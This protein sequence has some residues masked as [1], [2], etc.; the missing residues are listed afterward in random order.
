[1]A[2]SPE[3]TAA[4]ERLL[5]ESLGETAR[6]DWEES[7]IGY[8]RINR[9]SAQTFSQSVPLRIILKFPQKPERWPR[10]CNDWAGSR[11]LQSVPGTDLIGPRCFGGDSNLHF[12]LSQEVKGITFTDMLA[13]SVEGGDDE[14]SGTAW[15]G[16]VEFGRTLGRLHASTYGFQSDYERIRKATGPVEEH[17]NFEL[18]GRLRAT[19]GAIMALCRDWEVD[20]D[21]R[22]VD[23]INVV[24]QAIEDARFYLTYTHIDLNP[25]NL[26]RAPQGNVR[27]I[28]FDSGAYRH[29]LL[30]GVW[31]RLCF[32]GHW[33]AC[34]LPDELLADFETAYRQ[35]LSPAF[36]N[37]V[38]DDARFDR[39][40]TDACAFWALIRIG[41]VAEA[42]FET[43]P[44]PERIAY[45]R[46]QATVVL[47]R[48]VRTV[49]ETEERLELGRMA[50]TMLTF[51]R[52]R[53]GDSPSALIQPFP[54]FAG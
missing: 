15:A 16:L 7:V 20:V 6:I 10:L 41:W 49:N 2:L 54:V 29:A 42:T 23:E 32:P 5:S 51:A 37:A 14:A 28:D 44:K 25:N 22:L 30:D 33:P 39:A 38:D 18:P 24:I 11:F 9:G 40:V 8:P 27:I 13:V 17:V 36:G 43:D 26:L 21:D 45:L 19:L 1:M 35:E 50:E 31:C 48:F 53:W 46:R 47:D 52:N 4:A 34:F 12:T 3:I